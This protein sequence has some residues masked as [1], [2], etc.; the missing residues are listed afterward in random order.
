M[1]GT[2]AIPFQ[3]GQRLSDRLPRDTHS[4]R[5][6]H[7]KDPGVCQ[8]TGRPPPL[9]QSAQT[10]N[11]RLCAMDATVM[12]AQRVQLRFPALFQFIPRVF[13]RSRRRYQNDSYRLIRIRYIP[14]LQT[15][16]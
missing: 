5:L 13:E 7:V 6:G 4:P 9:L 14:I 16:D 11:A 1:V 10:R 8:S 12:Q 2:R 3:S 15:P